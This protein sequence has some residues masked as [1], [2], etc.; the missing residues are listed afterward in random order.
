MD[1]ENMI[2]EKHERAEEFQDK[3]AA[4]LAQ[5]QNL[6]Q[7]IDERRHR[8]DDS[9][10]VQQ[11]LFDCGEAEAWM[12]EQ[13][14]YM[15]SDAGSTA[16]MLPDSVISDLEHEPQQLASSDRDTQS[17]KWCKDEQ[18]AQNQLKKH[19]QL[20][21]EVEDHAAN[22]QALGDKCR[23]LTA[24]AKVQI[25]EDGTETA[26]LISGHLTDALSKRQMQIDKLYAGLKDLA[27][28]RRLRLEETVKLFMLHRDIDDLEQWIAD[29]VIVA[30]SNELGQDF[31]HVELLKERF[32]QF[33]SDT[34][35]IGQERVNHV[36]QI[37]N[38]LIDAGHADSSIIAQWNENLNSA[39]EDLLEL[40]RTRTQMLQSSW[41]LQK[42]FSDCKELLSHIDEKKKS[43]P[44]EVGRDAQTVAQLQRRHAT[45][46]ESDLLTLGGKVSQIQD[47]ASK[48]HNLYAGDRAK[49]IRDKEQQVLN[50]WNNLQA[51]TGVRKRQLTDMNDL[52]K[53]F[54]MSRDLMMWMETQMRQMRNDDKPRDVSGVELLI[55]NHQ[56]LKAEIDA[57]VENFTICLNLGK[58]LCNRH[59][60]RANEVKDKCV[61]LCMQRDRIS[62]EWTNRWELLQLMLEVYQFA[63]DAAVAEQW[64]VAQEPYLLNDDLGETLD[65]VEQLIKKHETFEK[66]IL[67][68][69][70]RFNALRKLTT[71]ELKQ[72]G[73]GV[74]SEDVSEE[75]DRVGV[76][77]IRPKK[78]ASSNLEKSRMSLY[79]EEFKT[80]E[81]REKDLESVRQQEQLVK[82][83]ESQ[84]KR[85]QELRE[86]EAARKR[87]AEVL[88]VAEAMA[89]VGA[90]TLQSQ[91]SPSVQRKDGDAN[92]E[93][94]YEGVLSRKHEWESVNRKA[95][96]RSWDKV[97]VVINAWNRYE[98]YKDQK[99]FKNVSFCGFFVFV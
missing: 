35:Q 12:G 55:N 36:S 82:D 73:S 86:K 10:Q 94:R 37:A 85:E 69:E 3:I 24:N 11:Y 9:Q 33:A 15:M 27:Q 1:G 68:Q 6:K 47:E 74:K 26:V 5:W 80:I 32:R 99:H 66:S 23:E 81:E 60:P 54:N 34:Q 83:A 57:R 7:A 25:N 4:L 63:R 87:A 56:S 19:T 43:I 17:S 40:I 53:F 96:S 78:D 22:I 20:E 64:L 16:P 51:V 77:Q 95:S 39:W 46:E 50:E 84:V 18:N 44:E 91:G 88:G 48:L 75:S 76:V 41:E 92:A 72:G 52:Y 2:E 58:D 67:A 8:L 79:L 30:D 59:H 42:F 45:F 97:Y 38:V 89:S 13:E 62:D 98:F 14:L 71:L 93:V 21:G 70:E 65:Q 90:S 61:Q 28:E 49:E 31:E 29:K